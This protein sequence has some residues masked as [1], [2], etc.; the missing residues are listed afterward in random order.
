MK[1]VQ[2]DIKDF[3]DIKQYKVAG[4]RDSIILRNKGL[5]PIIEIAGHPFFFHAAS[6]LAQPWADFSTMGIDLK[7]IPM[8]PQTRR[9]VFDYHVPSKS[10][11]TIGKDITNFPADV[12]RIDMPNMYYLD[13]V[14][15]A[16]RNDK[17]LRYYVGDGIPMKMYRVAK[18]ISLHR[19]EV[20][21]LV[22]DNRKKTGMPE[23]ELREPR[24]KTIG[25]PKR[26]TLKGL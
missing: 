2:P 9:L 15:M 8:H 7:N 6:G 21:K 23:L 24:Q 26:K 3:Y 25:R 17:P 10:R 4:K 1:N 11:V 22:R 16:L 19:T 5:L 12:V 13:P 18:V 14:G 20:A